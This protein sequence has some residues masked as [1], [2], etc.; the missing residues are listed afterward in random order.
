MAQILFR[1]ALVSGSLQTGWAILA[2]GNMPALTVVVA[3]LYVGWNKV[4]VGARER[5]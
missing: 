4:K 2:E 1:L 3:M 5:S